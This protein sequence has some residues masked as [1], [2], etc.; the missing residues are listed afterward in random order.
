[1]SSF[2]FMMVTQISHIQSECQTVDVVE[3][4][5]YFKRQA[6]TSLDYSTSSRVVAFLTGSLNVQSIHHTLPS[7]SNVHYVDLYPKF[8]AL[9]VKHGC[10]PAPCENILGAIYRHLLYVWRLGSDAADEKLPEESGERPPQML[11]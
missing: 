2:M 10:E 1:M 8:H 3:E 6:R 9:C 11:V 4:P 7:L 5:D